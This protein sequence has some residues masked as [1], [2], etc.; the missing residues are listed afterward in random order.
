MLPSHGS[1]FKLTVSWGKKNLF[2]SWIYKL[3]GNRPI[4]ASSKWQ[5]TKPWIFT[6]QHCTNSL[7][8][9]TLSICHQATAINDTLANRRY[10]HGWCAPVY[11]WLSSNLT[12]GKLFSRSSLLYHGWR[13]KK[14]YR[15]SWT[16]PLAA[17]A[18]WL[19]ARADSWGAVGPAEQ[20]RPSV[21]TETRKVCHSALE[22]GHKIWIYMTQFTLV[23][24]TPSYDTTGLSL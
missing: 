21:M 1:V 12:T 18:G 3:L 7:K 23:L 4:L 2:Y 19:V 8:T 5:P 11:S 16:R 13:H 15:S 24:T 10:H 9:L 20:R 6:P 22:I 17:L 14:R